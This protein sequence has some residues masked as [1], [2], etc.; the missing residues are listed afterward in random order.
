VA[1][2][3]KFTT[4][5]NGEK[6]SYWIKYTFPDAVIVESWREDKMFEVTYS[7]ADDGSIILGDL[8][9]VKEQ[10][11]TKKIEDF[12]NKFGG[13]EMVLSKEEMELIGK[14]MGDALGE[15][16]AGPL[17]A[18]TKSNEK[19]VET[20]TDE[21]GEQGG[22]QGASN[23]GSKDGGVEETTPSEPSEEEMENFAK[24]VAPLILKQMG[25]NDE[26][27]AEMQ[28]SQEPPASNDGEM[29]TINGMEMSQK[30]A[31]KLLEGQM[32]ERKSG[33]KAPKF[34]NGGKFGGEKPPEEKGGNPS[35]KKT[36]SLGDL[37]KGFCERN[38]L[39]PTQK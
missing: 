9:E 37:A 25:F 38:G 35:D 30:D 7:F 6:T 5:V 1:V 8:Q 16:I 2:N 14:S 36:K 24:S 22:A 21:G 18:I 27:I 31:M 29:V 34:T 12:K 15:K 19:L 28:K 3:N 11:V 4:T 39:I 17:D 23:E 32:G 33:G 26:Q 13:S 10:Y 20:L